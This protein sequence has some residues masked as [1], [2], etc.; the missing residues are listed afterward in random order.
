[1]MDFIICIFFFFDFIRN[2]YLADSKLSYMKWGWLDLL[3]SI[4]MVDIIRFGRLLRII[5]VFRLIKA[6]RSAHSL[7]Q[8][9][10][11]NKAKGTFNSVVILCVLLIMFGSISILQFENLPSSNI[12]T[13]EDAIYW[14]FVTVVTFGHENLYA[15][16]TLGRVVEGILIVSGMG[17]MG[18]F[19]AYVA[20]WFL[21]PQS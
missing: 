5:R 20:S 6:F 7:I 17:L 21:K 14:A 10:Y 9:V 4:P 12:K 11:A 3:A 16:T 15:T 1:M 8:H 2:F 18:T 19:T 13:A